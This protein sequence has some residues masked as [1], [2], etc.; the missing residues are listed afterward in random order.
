M[1]ILSNRVPDDPAFTALNHKDAFAPS[2]SDL[3]LHDERVHTIC[4]SQRDVRL[5]VIRNFVLLDDPR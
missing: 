3:I 1:Y 5:D 4:P 2:S